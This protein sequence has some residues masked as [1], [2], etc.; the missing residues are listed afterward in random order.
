MARITAI[1]TSGMAVQ[2][3]NVHIEDNASFGEE[4]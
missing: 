1:L 3:S 2:I 4:D